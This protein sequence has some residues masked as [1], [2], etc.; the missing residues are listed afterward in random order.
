MMASSQ[1]KSIF[2]NYRRRDSSAIAR[3][4][5]ETIEQNF[6]KASVFIDTDAIEMGDEWPDRIDTALKRASA[7]IVVIGPEWLRSHDE[8]SRRRLDNP[9]DW[10][11]KEII[12]ALENKLTIIPLLVSNAEMPESV[13]TAP[14]I[15]YPKP[16][17]YPRSLTEEELGEFLEQHSAWRLIARI[18]AKGEK[19]TELMRTYEF[20]SFEDA[21]HFMF[22]ATRHIS[23][24]NHHPD[25]ENIWRTVTVWL[26]TWDIRHNPSHYDIELAQYLDDLY[27]T[28]VSS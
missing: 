25:W 11:R 3:W 28:Y 10:V 26:T 15:R 8:F 4:L 24:V 17:K 19:R 21:I 18:G 7:L 5:G 9:K 6:G 14:Q 2:I 1:S 16:A 22:S 23:K 13:R 20:A 27:S 12:Y